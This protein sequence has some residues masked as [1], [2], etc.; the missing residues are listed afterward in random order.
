MTCRNRLIISLTLSLIFCGANLRAM[1]EV[2]N[3][4]PYD[5]LIRPTC[6]NKYRWQTAVY[7]E[8]GFHHAKGFN[9]GGDLVNVL[10]IYNNQQNAL[11]MLEG[12]PQFS[13]ADQL[14]SALLDSNNGIRGRFIING[15]LKLDFNFSVAA[16]L[17]FSQDWSVGL[18]LPV[19]KMKLTN[20]SLLDQTPNLDNMDKLVRQFLTNNIIA[21]VQQFGGLRIGDWDRTGL[22]D[23][24]LL[25]EWFRDFYQNKPFL[26]CVRVNW[27]AGLAFPTGLRENEDLIFA[28]PFGYDGAFS[29]PFGLGLDLTMGKHFKCGIDIQLTQ[30]FGNTR[31]RRIKT[32]LDQTE[33]FLLQKTK[34]YKDFGLTQRFNLY[35]ELYNFFKGLS[36]KAG[37]Q[38]LKHGDDELSL[39]TQE[40]SS[41]IAN[42]SRK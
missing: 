41:N 3:M 39:I 1:Y 40:F 42:T 26:K 36:F 29:M 28:V 24:T 14:R 35:V 33:L 31:T 37:Y 8:T 15:D 12:S 23:L 5:T 17:F 19:Y 7:A 21:N 16:R 25:F 11:A 27:R 20:V 18:Y 30:I 38:F 2:N 32:Q 34:A 10:Q 9:D 4:W 13:A 22:G 6:T